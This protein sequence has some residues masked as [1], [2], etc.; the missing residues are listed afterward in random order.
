MIPVFRP[1]MNDEEIEA[2][3]QVLRSGWIG[4]G[5]KTKE[6]EEQ[7]AKYIGTRHAVALS[8]CTA[9]LHLALNA[10]DIDSGEVITTPITFVSTVHA[11]LYNNAT[12]VFA[13]VQEDTLNIDPSDIER[14]ITA[15]TKAIIPVHYGGHACDMDEILDIA[16]QHDLCVIE[17]AAHACGAEYKGKKAGS[18]G[19]IGCFSFH[20]VKN[21]ATG[22]G[23]M[24]TNNDD[25]IY[26]K[27]RKLRWVGINQD[28]YQRN[29]EGYSWHYD[30]DC[31][32]FKAHMNDITASIGLVQLKRLDKV[33]AKRR[34]IVNRYNEEFQKLEWLETPVERRYVKSSLHNYVIK[35]KHGDR[36]RLISHL[37]RKGISASVHYL[38]VY[39]HPFYRKLGVKGDCVVANR[40]WETLVT[41]PLY[42]G[43]SEADIDT[44]INGVKS[45]EGT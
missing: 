2:V 19:D 26:E 30:V 13:D 18:L 11:I 36:N 29:I 20:A 38:P 44:V 25:E 32:G 42:P 14:K 35:V 31:L 37:G 27:L 28:T 40:V 39:L 33:N 43:M 22:D 10:M 1:F 45:W 41:L 34:E 16:H 4:L 23:G 24:I 15:K 9:A 21:L 12:P 17:D 6:F 7:F 5:P 3:A 8:S